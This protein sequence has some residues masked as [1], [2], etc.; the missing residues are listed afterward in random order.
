[1]RATCDICNKQRHANDVEK[2]TIEG[3]DKWVC[4]LC[5][6]N[7]R[8]QAWLFHKEKEAMKKNT[9]RATWFYK[10]ETPYSTSAWPWQSHR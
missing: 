7:A 10:R 2:M 6:D 9:N 1:M 3:A 4:A 8:T 5:V